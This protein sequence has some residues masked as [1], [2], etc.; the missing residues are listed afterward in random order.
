LDPGLD[1]AETDAMTRILLIEDSDDDATIVG[2]LLDEAL[3]AD[4]S[5]AVTMD[6]AGG[7]SRLESE[8]FDLVLVDLYL[9]DS[10]GIETF[11][12]AHRAA[13]M[14]PIVVLT[15]LDSDDVA[16]EA[17]A[18][19]AQD[20]LVKG[21]I[22]ADRLGRAIRHSIERQ[23]LIGDLLHAQRLEAI[24]RLAGGIAH[25]FNNLLQVIGGHADLAL[26]ESDPERTKSSLET[27]RN[28]THRGSALVLQLLSFSRKQVLQPQLIDLNDLLRGLVRM[29]RPLLGERILLR[30][31]LAQQLGMV[32]VDPIQLEQAIVNLAVNARDAMPGGGSLVFTTAAAE[33]GDDRRGLLRELDAGSYVRLTVRDT[34]VG[35]DAK[36]LASIFEPYFTTKKSG[37]GTG[38]GLAMVHD[39]VRRSA[40]EIEV[41]SQP[42]LGTT[43]RLFLPRV[44]GVV[45]RPPERQP[46]PAVPVGGN[47]LVVDDQPDVLGLI[48]RALER[49]GH[50]VAT[51][52]DGVKA[53]GLVATA[54][55]PFDVVLTDIAMPRIGGIEL[56]ER[57]RAS[58]PDTRVVYMS[59]FVSESRTLGFLRPGDLFLEKPF[60]VADLLTRVNEA[61]AAREIGG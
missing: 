51:A 49:A 34:G 48:R 30:L 22:D 56:V 47:V 11:R 29:I 40:G 42:G 21:G 52:G 50:R 14:V 35:L 60:S 25:E 54:E 23:R 10:R 32:R 45:D 37:E 31:E 12:A 46:A 13:P 4:Y 2:E 26:S 8:S 41:E 44:A 19:G 18:G 61:L 24:G 3:G 55:Q 38:L 53:L 59:G 33:L 15:G 43:F 36:A 20:F 58:R 39:F 6:L 1:R 17:L 16:R 7:L 27:I 57:M 5:L 28:A 9:P